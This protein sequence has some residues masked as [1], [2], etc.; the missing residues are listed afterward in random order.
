VSIRALPRPAAVRAP[1]PRVA[2]AGASSV[3]FCALAALVS[4]GRLTGFDQLAVRH[5]MPGLYPYFAHGAVPGIDVPISSANNP[6]RIVNRV[7]DA[8]MLPAGAILSSALFVLVALARR[9]APAATV[10]WLAAYA[11]GNAIELLGKTLL[12]RPALVTPPEWGSAHV[13]KFDSSFPS[14]HTIRALLLASLVA[15]SSRRLRPLA[16]AWAAAVTVLLV[17]AGTHTPSDVLGGVL[18]CVA[19]VSLCREVEARTA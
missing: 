17:A 16:A 2:V 19:L 15:A 4:S 6:G 10:C 12:R 18:V 3:A 9:S 13:W 1:S 5:L 8:V 11:A 14:G 7:A